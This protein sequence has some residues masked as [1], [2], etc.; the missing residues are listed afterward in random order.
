[1]QTVFVN[2]HFVRQLSHE[3]THTDT[4]TDTQHTHSTH[5]DRLYYLDHMLLVQSS[6]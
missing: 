6:N 5:T 3:H 4:H 1:V 2:G